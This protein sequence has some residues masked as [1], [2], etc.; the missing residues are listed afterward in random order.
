MKMKQETFSRMSDEYRRPLLCI[1]FS[2]IGT[3]IMKWS[4]C[5]W[6][7]ISSDF[8]YVCRAI[9]AVYLF[10]LKFLIR[11]TQFKTIA[12]IDMEPVALFA[13]SELIDGRLYS[14][15]LH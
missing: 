15:D 12:K 6:Q 13:Q 9:D 11:Q 3:A 4:E 2:V 7:Q 5:S 1:T 8:D 14:L 10:F